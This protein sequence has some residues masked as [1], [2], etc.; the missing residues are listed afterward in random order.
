MIVRSLQ[1]PVAGAWRSHSWVDDYGWHLVSKN[2]ATWFWF[3]VNDEAADLPF[4]REEG[5]LPEITVISV[6]RDGQVQPG[7][8]L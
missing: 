1:G 2:V 6:V 5:G 8:P 7:M 3:Y 4:P